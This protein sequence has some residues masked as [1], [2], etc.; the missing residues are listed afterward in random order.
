MGLRK[1]TFIE[2]EYYHIFNR[3]NGRREIFRDDNDKSHFVKL[4][5]LCNSKKPLNFRD[6]INTKKANPWIYDRGESIV[7]VGAWVLMP[8]HFHLYLTIP[9]GRTF[10]NNISEFMRKLCTAYTMY[11][12]NKYSVSGS[13]FEGKF[14]AVHITDDDQAKYIFSY[15]HLNPIKL[16]DPQWKQKGIRDK[17]AALRYLR[18]YTWSSYLDHKNTQ[19]DERV[20]VDMLNFP[21]Y[22]STA[23]DFDKEI[24]S[25][26]TMRVPDVPTPEE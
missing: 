7:S 11:F 6:E 18:S 17:N 10:G 1:I 19:R 2:G 13:L 24:M 14:K 26:L 16:I 12:N 5:Y 3:G 21:S 9:K 22:F 25:W 23:Q 4:L 15:I 20:I 8:N